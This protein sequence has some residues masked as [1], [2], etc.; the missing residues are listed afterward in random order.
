MALRQAKTGDYPWPPPGAPHLCS[1]VEVRLPKSHSISTERVR[2]PIPMPPLRRLQ[3]TRS[4]WSWKRHPSEIGEHP[5]MATCIQPALWTRPRVPDW[6]PRPSCRPH[7]RSSPSRLARTGRPSAWCG[8]VGHGTR[9]QSEFDVSWQIIRDDG[10]LRGD[11]RSC[12]QAAAREHNQQRSAAYEW[13]LTRWARILW[14][15]ASKPALDR[16]Y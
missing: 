9:S 15:R 3:T 14:V 16:R 11:S 5:Q 12:W 1:L 6:P 13:V 8:R 4:V 7:R 2:V 10:Q